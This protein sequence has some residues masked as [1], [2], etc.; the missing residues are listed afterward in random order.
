MSYLDDWPLEE[1]RKKLHEIGRVVDAVF[2]APDGYNGGYLILWHDQAGYTISYCERQAAGTGGVRSYAEA[3]AEF[4]ALVRE[5]LT[6]I[7]PSAAALRE[8]RDQGSP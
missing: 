4:L 6:R 3:A 7:A 1:H 8:M 2:E 5:M